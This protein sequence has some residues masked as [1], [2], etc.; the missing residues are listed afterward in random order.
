MFDY[1]LLG[2]VPTGE[3]PVVDKEDPEGMER[4]EM[5]PPEVRPEQDARPAPEEGLRLSPTLPLPLP[6]PR[7][8]PDA[9][10]APAAALPGTLLAQ[11]PARQ[12]R[13][14]RTPA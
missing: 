10:G 8:E 9:P 11:K 14:N 3:D 6:A 2:K 13:P 7:R 4:P 12:R 5:I 1:Y